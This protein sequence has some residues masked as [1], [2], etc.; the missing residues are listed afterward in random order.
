MAKAHSKA[1]SPLMVRLDEE[2][3]GV[4]TRAAELRG[5]SVS[6]YVRQVTVAQAR[7]EVTAA[8]EQTIAMTPDEQL[9]FWTA[10]STP[11]KLTAA[12]KALGKL[13]RGES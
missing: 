10:L 3:K 6:D 13:M 5:I 12:Q 11:V 9:A 1:A 2:S 7:K 4:L 8:H